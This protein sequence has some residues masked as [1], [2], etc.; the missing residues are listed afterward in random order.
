MIAYAGIGSRDISSEEETNISKIAN[1][2]QSKGLILY[3]GNAEGSDIAFQ[4]G[5]NGKCVVMLPWKTFNIKHYDYAQLAMDHII[6]G[7]RNNN[8]HKEAF[9]SIKKFHPKAHALNKASE[10]FMARNFYQINGFDKYPK[11]SIV[12]CCANSINKKGNV[13]GGTG[14][15][16][17]I[18]LSMNIPIIN[19]R[20]IGWTDKFNVFL[21]NLDIEKNLFQ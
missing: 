18:A 14:Q 7:S 3:S 12:I 6:V 2:L 8:F 1:I 17:R 20:E 13:M 21:K 10:T 16:V 19:I 4:K 9:D 5:S 15:A 11:A